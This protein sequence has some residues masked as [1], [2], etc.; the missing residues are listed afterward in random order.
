MTARR[1]RVHRWYNIMCGKTL[2]QTTRVNVA[3][4]IA[5]RIRSQTQ[6][7]IVVVLREAATTYEKPP[8]GHYSFMHRP[9][10]SGLVKAWEVLSDGRFRRLPVKRS[11]RGGRPDN[12]DKEER[13]N[14]LIDAAGGLV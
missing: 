9:Y 3:R 12:A 8:G 13:G 1:N 10:R 5:R 6:T 14:A 7:P 11:T 2:V 4:P